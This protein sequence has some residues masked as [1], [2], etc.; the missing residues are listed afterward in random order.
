MKSVMTQKSQ[1]HI[2]AKI[3]QA[4]GLKPNS[5]V[6]VAVVAGAVVITP[7]TDSVLALAGTFKQKHSISAETIRQ[8]LAYGEEK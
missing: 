7:A 6:D 8:H 1:V 2:P 4:A 3:R 5:Q